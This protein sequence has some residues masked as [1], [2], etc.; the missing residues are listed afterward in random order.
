M[1]VEGPTRERFREVLKAEKRRGGLEGGKIKE[2][3]REEGETGSKGGGRQQRT[4]TEA[5]G[6][7]QRPNE[8]GGPWD[9]RR[10]KTA[11]GMDGRIRVLAENEREESTVSSTCRF[12]VILLE[13]VVCCILAV[14]A[15][16]DHGWLV[17]C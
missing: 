2:D 15:E 7:L 17:N 3:V 10:G 12:A 6:K 14:E 8:G 1:G 5:R 9:D 13:E 11:K 16:E 4:L